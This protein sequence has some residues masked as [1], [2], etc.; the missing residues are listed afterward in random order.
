MKKLILASS[1]MLVYASGMA[2]I[3]PCAEIK[4]KIE[5]KLEGKGVKNYSLQVVSADTETKNRVVASCD[6]GRKKIIYQKS[7]KADV[8]E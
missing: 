1:L 5:A 3:T 6:G 2:A 7:H 4:E 8:T